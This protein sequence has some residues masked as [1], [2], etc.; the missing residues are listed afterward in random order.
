MRHY[1]LNGL[2]Q[3][4]KSLNEMTVNRAL[5]SDYDQSSIDVYV[6][7]DGALYK[8]QIMEIFKESKERRERSQTPQNERG[9]LITVPLRLG[10]EKLNPVY[11]SSLKVRIFLYIV[12]KI[13]G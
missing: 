6:A 12:L 8:N 10:V 5:V 2:E 7:T 3:S 13:F 4:L 11:F 1:F 9:L